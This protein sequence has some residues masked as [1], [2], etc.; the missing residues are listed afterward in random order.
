MSTTIL[1]SPERDAATRQA[2]RAQVR[3]RKVAEAHARPPDGT[4]II[5]GV[6]PMFPPFIAA[7][8][9]LPSAKRL[10]K[11]RI[12]ID[13]GGRTWERPVA[14]VERE[15]KRLWMLGRFA[16]TVSLSHDSEPQRPLFRGAVFSAEK[17]AA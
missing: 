14:W 1:I 2:Q 6:P 17:G 15:A 4:L 3:R 10:R 16:D 13:S 7:V 5:L 12:R 11:E 9:H 8:S